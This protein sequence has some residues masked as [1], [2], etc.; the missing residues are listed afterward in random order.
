MKIN[1][2]RTLIDTPCIGICSTTN[3]GDKICK[4]CGR[5]DEEVIHWNMYTLEKKCAINKRLKYWAYEE[6]S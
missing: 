2:E 1:G 3:V 6:E 4:G 5:T